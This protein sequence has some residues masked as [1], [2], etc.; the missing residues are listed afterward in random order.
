MSYIKEIKWDE[1]N[2]IPK[3]KVAVGSNSI[4]RSNTKRDWRPQSPSRD[5]LVEIVAQALPT[6]LTGVSRTVR[7]IGNEVW[8]WRYYQNVV[9]GEMKTYDMFGYAKNVINEV[10]GKFESQLT[11]G[12]GLDWR[13]RAGD[14][15][16]RR[17]IR[18]AQAMNVASGGS[19]DESAGGAR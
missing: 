10:Y 13:L 12:V 17:I 11:G 15:V 2:G 5:E 14:S 6:H 7:S 1:K 16:E 4:Y 18:F 3:P 9:W 8:G 19:W